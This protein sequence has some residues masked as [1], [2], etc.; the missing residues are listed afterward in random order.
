VPITFIALIAPGLRTLAH[1]VAALV[2]VAM[3]LA[4]AGL[5]WNLGLL[6][7]ALLAMAAGAEVE[8]CGFARPL[9]AERRA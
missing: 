5:P 2:A 4:L 6:A 1:L 8:R 7:A 3:G 9:R